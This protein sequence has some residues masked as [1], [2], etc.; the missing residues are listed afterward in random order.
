MEKNISRLSDNR[1]LFYEEGILGITNRYTVGIAGE[2]FLRHLKDEGK[3][4]GSR[5]GKCN[6]LYVPARMFCEKCFQEISDDAWEEVGLK[7]KLY[8]FT[9][10]HRD[11]DGR[12][13]DK[14]VVVGI[15]EFGSPTARLVHFLENAENIKCGDEF[16]AVLKPKDERRGSILDIEYFRKA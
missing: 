3:L 15:I 2:R 6:S 1:E 5:C 8:S 16:E 9:I 10:M 13:L 7:G 14:P 4:Y 11:I 12:P